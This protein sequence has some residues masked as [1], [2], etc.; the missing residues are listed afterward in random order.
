MNKN[1]I[2]LEL[3]KLIVTPASSFKDPKGK[4]YLNEPSIEKAQQVAEIFNTIYKA[5]HNE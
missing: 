3:T 4:A 5:I 2:A 1:E